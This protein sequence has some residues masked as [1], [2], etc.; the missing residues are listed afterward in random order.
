MKDC[1]KLT[2]LA[3]L[4]F[5][6][7]TNAPAQGHPNG[8]RLALDFRQADSAGQDALREATQDKTHSFRYLKIESIEREPAEGRTRR[9]R[10]LTTEPSSAMQI[11]VIVTGRQSLEL[12]NK[13]EI[14]DAIAADG[15]VADLGQ[16][17]TNRMVL[18]P[19]RIN[20]KDRESPK[21]GPELLRETDPD[22]H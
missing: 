17:N 15:R 2:V 1:V 7:S 18:Q 12:V 5:V 20:S 21:P 14:G 19:A 6:T 16:A 9:V 10:L 3:F 11:H 22:A 4:V 13:L 8:N